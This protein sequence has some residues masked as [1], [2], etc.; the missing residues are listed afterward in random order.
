MRLRNGF[1]LIFGFGTDF[2]PDFPL[3]GLDF[4][5]MTPHIAAITRESLSRNIGQVIDNICR[6]LEGDKPL[7]LVNDVWT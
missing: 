2:E 1:G 3:T 4:I 6:F 7:Y 5:V